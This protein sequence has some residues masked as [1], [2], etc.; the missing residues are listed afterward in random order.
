[1]QNTANNA[2]KTCG[3]EKK[4]CLFSAVAPRRIRQEAGAWTCVTILYPSIPIVQINAVRVLFF[5]QLKD[6]T[7]CDSFE[8]ALSSPMSTEQLWAELIGKF[9]TL[10]K[11]RSSVRLAKN[12]EYALP[13]TQF[14]DADEVA[15]I[16][17]VSG[18]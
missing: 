11:H 18:G 4:D 8:L 15:L 1:M 6:V 3:F 13:N 7:K 14:S 16:P 9:P 2:H 12:Q 10:A 17:P 5:A